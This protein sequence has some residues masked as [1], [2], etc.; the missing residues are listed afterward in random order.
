VREFWHVTGPKAIA[1][2][3]LATHNND[4]WVVM[5]YSEL[6]K[7]GPISGLE[8]QCERWLSSF[9]LLT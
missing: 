2:Q 1:V 5:C 8:Q 9:Q 4:G 6:G 3:V 7:A